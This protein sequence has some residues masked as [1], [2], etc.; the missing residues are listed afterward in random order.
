MAVSEPP[1][2]EKYHDTHLLTAA[3]PLSTSAL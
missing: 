1:Y 3:S 2:L